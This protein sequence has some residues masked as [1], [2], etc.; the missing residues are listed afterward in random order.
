VLFEP[1][2]SDFRTVAVIP[3]DLLNIEHR[4]AA[5]THDSRVLFIRRKLYWEQR[6]LLRTEAVQSLEA[7]RIRMDTRFQ[8]PRPSWV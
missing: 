6:W 7:D 4:M 3:R 5:L 8:G 2:Y 1:M